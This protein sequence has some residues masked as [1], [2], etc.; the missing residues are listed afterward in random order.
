MLLLS[1]AREFRRWAADSHLHRISIY[2]K[3]CVLPGDAH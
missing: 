3:D 1:A 2:Q